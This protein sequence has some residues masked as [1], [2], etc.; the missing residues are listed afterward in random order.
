MSEMRYDA[1]KPSEFYDP[2]DFAALKNS[3]IPATIAASPA[4]RFDSEDAAAVLLT[5]ELHSI[6]Y[7]PHDEQ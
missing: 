2:A 7:K 1:N 6:Q 5:R 4:M 3:N